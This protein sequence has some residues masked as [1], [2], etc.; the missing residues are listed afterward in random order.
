M[1]KFTI[2]PLDSSTG[3]IP[4]VT[5]YLAEYGDNG[6]LSSVNKG[7][8]NADG[9]LEITLPTTDNY[10]FMLWDIDQCPLINAIANIY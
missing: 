9:K 1:Y 4:S 8:K 6:Q 7:V 5:L 2:T 3:E 10:K